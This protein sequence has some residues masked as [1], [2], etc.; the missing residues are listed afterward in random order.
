MESFAAGISALGVKPT[1]SSKPAKR[2]WDTVVAKTFLRR[3]LVSS[4]F[5]RGVVE[6]DPGFGTCDRFPVERFDVQIKSAR[7]ALKQHLP[8]SWL[9]LPV[10]TS[11]NVVLPAPLGPI[12]TRNSPTSM[13]KFSWF[14][15]LKPSK[16]T[17][18]SSVSKIL[19]FTL[20]L[21]IFFETGMVAICLGRP[22]CW[23]PL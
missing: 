13:L 20:Y 19:P 7:Y 6:V 21:W 12:T 11:R 2:S 4:R 10:I 16:L 1:V 3:L 5:S 23:I 18:R 9:H 22:T 17:V 14:S 8:L 15:A